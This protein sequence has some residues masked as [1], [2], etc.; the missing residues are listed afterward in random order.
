[1]TP[2][3]VTTPMTPDLIAGLR[4]GD[5]VEITGTLYTAR[6]AAHKRLAEALQA[7]D[8]LPIE[9]DRQIIYYVGPAPARPGMVM[10]SAGPTTSG[11]MD[12]YTSALLEAGLKG[13]IGKGYRNQEVR[14]AITR[15][16]AVYFAAV[17]GS[18]ALLARRIHAAEVVAYEDL[19][20]EAIYR[21]RV[22][23]FPA[24]VVNDCN[25]NDLY[26]IAPEQYRE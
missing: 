26:Q 9:L 25:G 6:D 15:H 4:A 22:E 17:G 14:D 12:R 18:G 2:K 21:L 8:R 7:G 3:Q 5:Q 10:G 16:G 19:G 13:M 1:L 23:R 11:R 20:P 24:I